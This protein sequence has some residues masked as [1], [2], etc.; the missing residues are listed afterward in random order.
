[1]SLSRRAIGLLSRL[2]CPLCPSREN[3]VWGIFEGSFLGVAAD[4]GMA[5]LEKSRQG[6][7]M[8]T[9]AATWPRT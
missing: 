3:G 1:M 4:I 7:K 2:R 9:I 8:V 5:A 6:L